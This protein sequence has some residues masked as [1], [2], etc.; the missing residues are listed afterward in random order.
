MLSFHKRDVFIVKI[1]QHCLPTKCWYV[2]LAD[3]FV[4]LI[5]KLTGK[6]WDN[7]ASS[8]I[9]LWHENIEGEVSFPWFDEMSRQH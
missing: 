9:Q 6:E 2:G 7:N 4:R 1:K 8:M 5:V 3:Q